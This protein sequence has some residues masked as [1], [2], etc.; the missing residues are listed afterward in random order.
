MKGL[1]RTTRGDCDQPK[2][3]HFRGRIGSAPEIGLGMEQRSKEEWEAE[4]DVEYLS[5]G[6][7]D[8]ET[9]GDDGG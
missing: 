3:G 4:R 8:V 6:R 7:D 1:R 2:D 9:N 5:S